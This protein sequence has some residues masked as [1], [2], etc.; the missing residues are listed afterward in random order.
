[1]LTTLADE[2]HWSCVEVAH[3]DTRKDFLAAIEAL[4]SSPTCVVLVPR[5]GHIDTGRI[6]LDDM[7]DRAGIL[8][9]PIVAAALLVAQRV[10]FHTCWLGST[11]V[12][13][14]DELGAN[15]AFIARLMARGIIEFTL[16]GFE[17]PIPRDPADGDR[18][19]A[20]VRHG[21]LNVW[22]R[23]HDTCCQRRAL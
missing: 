21:C 4:D 16:S 18:H 1:M 13:L 5:H 20:Y 23:R 14:V 17:T 9:A 6:Q 7:V 22:S 19:D 2:R 10:H 3:A 12:G 11:L 8:A 15:N